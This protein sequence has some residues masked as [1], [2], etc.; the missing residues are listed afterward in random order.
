MDIGKQ[1]YLRVC[2]AGFLGA[3]L[4]PD[5]IVLECL[6]WRHSKNISCLVVSIFWIKNPT[7]V[8]GFSGNYLGKVMAT[9]YSSQINPSSARLC[10]VLSAFQ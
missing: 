1:R 5:G 8:A 10:G 3:G 4:R 7:T 2:K 9:L 6:L